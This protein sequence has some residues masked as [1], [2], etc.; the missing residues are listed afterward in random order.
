MSTRRAPRLPSRRHG[1]RRSTNSVS[2]KL[3][4]YLLSEEVS[5]GATHRLYK[6]IDTRTL[7]AFQMETVALKD[8]NEEKKKNLQFEV[9][10]L[11][12]LPPHRNIIQY[13][14]HVQDDKLFGIVLEYIDMGSLHSFIRKYSTNI[15]ITERHV[16]SWIYQICNDLQFIHE[17]SIIRRD[18]RAVE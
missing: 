15:D 10:I 1:A 11:R 7:K 3:G 8:M 9:D 18:I 4:H 2:Q 16:A 13:I 6:C 5:R 14:D 12:S 17:Q